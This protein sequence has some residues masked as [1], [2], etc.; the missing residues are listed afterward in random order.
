MN[1]LNTT[2]LYTWRKRILE[3]ERGHYYVA[4]AFYFTD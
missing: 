2:K 1:I 3:V 4:L